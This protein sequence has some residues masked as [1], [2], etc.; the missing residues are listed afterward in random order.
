MNGAML[1]YRAIVFAIGLDANFRSPLTSVNGLNDV[2]HK[3]N[4]TDVTL[5]YS[6][7]GCFASGINSVD[8]NCVTIVL[9]MLCSNAGLR[10]SA[11]LSIGSKNRESAGHTHYNCE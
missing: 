7:A 5:I 10:T 9:G 11:G 2:V 4:F 6:V 1:G 8:L 3:V